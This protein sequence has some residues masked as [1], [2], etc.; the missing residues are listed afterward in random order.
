[1]RNEN[2]KTHKLSVENEAK[3][4][5]QEEENRQLQIKMAADLK[6]Q[7]RIEKEKKKKEL[8]LK[9]LKGTILF[10]KILLCQIS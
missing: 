5:K 10:I 6:E 3:R 4:I 8:I 9:N 1:M 7:K 2:L